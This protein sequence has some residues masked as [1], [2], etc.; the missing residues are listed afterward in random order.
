MD[1]IY[2]MRNQTIINDLDDIPLRHHRKKVHRICGE[3][4]I[5]VFRIYLSK[6][7]S[8]IFSP[9]SVNKYTLFYTVYHTV[10][11]LSTFLKKF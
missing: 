5:L 11:T 3:I 9:K 10:P 6:Y 7:L 4:I 2:V 8:M 1:T